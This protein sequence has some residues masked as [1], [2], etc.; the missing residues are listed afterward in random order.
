MSSDFSASDTLRVV[1]DTSI[2][3]AAFLKPGLSYG[4]VIK[5]LEGEFQ[6]Y[7]SVAI[8][9]ELTVKLH[10]ERLARASEAAEKFITLIKSTCH[11]VTPTE[12]LAVIT[13]DPSDNRILECAVAANASVIVSL[14]NDL[15]RLKN[16]HGIAIIHPKTFTW[17]VPEAPNTSE[18]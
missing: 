3:V 12:R 9:E 17:I 8:T 11:I 2:Y 18:V 6:L 7:T 16:W 1:F 15:L 13:E 10:S 4:L 14:D 5:A